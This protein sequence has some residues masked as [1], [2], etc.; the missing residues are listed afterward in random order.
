[1]PYTIVNKE[2]QFMR[3]IYEIIFYMSNLSDNDKIIN[4]GWLS[5]YVVTA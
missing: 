1:M 3:S 4:N 5:G 2:L